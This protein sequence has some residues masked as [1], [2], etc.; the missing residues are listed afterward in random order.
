MTDSLFQLTD[1]HYWR[2][3]GDP[4]HK[5]YLTDYQDRKVLRS[6]HHGRSRNDND[7]LR[8]GTRKAQGKTVRL[9]PN[10]LLS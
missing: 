4:A 1:Y 9:L 6:S 8:V 2:L 3:S 10:R 7:V 5:Y